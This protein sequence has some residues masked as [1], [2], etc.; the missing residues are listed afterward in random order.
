MFGLYF[1]GLSFMNLKIVFIMKIKI[2]ICTYISFFLKNRLKHLKHIELT[3]IR[4]NYEDILEL[5]G[6]ILC[7]LTVFFTSY[8]EAVIYLTINIIYLNIFI[9]FYSDFNRNRYT[10]LLG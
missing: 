10:A 5:N 4:K 7:S 6:N 2:C 3:W 8:E 9:Q 1:I